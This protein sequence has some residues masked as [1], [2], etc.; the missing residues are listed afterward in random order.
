GPLVAPTAA[1]ATAAVPTASAAPAAASFLARPG[2]IDRQRPTAD[3]LA[4]ER[5]NGVLG[6]LVAAHLHEAEALGST[7]VA[8]HDDLRR[9]DRAVWGEHRLQ[10]G[11]GHVVSQIPNVQLPAHG[12][13]PRKRHRYV[14]LLGG[15]ASR[16][17]T[18]G[19]M[20]Q[21]KAREEGASARKT[22]HETQV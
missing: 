6:F 5:L 22:I 8:I 10:R 21:E 11:I 12:G 13:P 9:L 14:P 3:L 16:P 20:G 18:P 1:P 17:E 7:R 4:V 19:Y 15:A 2:F